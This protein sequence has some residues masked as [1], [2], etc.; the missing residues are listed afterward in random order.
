MKYFEIGIIQF[1]MEIVTSVDNII[2]QVTSGSLFRLLE[3]EG[4]ISTI[5]IDQQYDIIF[6]TTIP[7][8]SRHLQFINTTFFHL[9]TIVEQYYI[10]HDEGEIDRITDNYIWMVFPICYSSER[11]VDLDA[12]PTTD[13]S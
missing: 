4:I 3:D 8:D 9:K 5:L 6:I 10:L 1:Q 11:A 2:Q 12:I 13:C 7:S